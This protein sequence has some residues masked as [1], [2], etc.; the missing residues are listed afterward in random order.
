VETKSRQTS[1]SLE[2]E[3]ILKTATDSMEQ[4]AFGVEALLIRGE[5]ENADSVIDK[6]LEYVDDSDYSLTDWLSALLEFDKWLVG[7]KVDARPVETMIGYIHCSTMGAPQ[8]LTAP[9]LS[10]VVLENLDEW[11]FD[12][13]KPIML[14]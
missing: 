2:N 12:A 4:G 10:R 9:E 3:K 6:L 13:V 14:D 7:E 1:L 11:G 8:T 5:L